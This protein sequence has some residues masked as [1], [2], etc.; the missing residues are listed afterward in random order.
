MTFE[1]EPDAA[2][3]LKCIRRDLN[4]EL[5]PDLQSA[6][7][8]GLAMMIDL[9]LRNVIAKEE[10]ASMLSPA[11]SDK[12]SV[13]AQAAF[14]RACDELEESQETLQATPEQAATL[15]VTPQRLTQYLRRRQPDFPAQRAVRVEPILGGFSKHTF[16]ADLQGGPLQSIVIRRD[17]KNG[18]IDSTASAEFA[19]VSTLYRSGIPVAEPL[20]VEQD[21][22]VFG[23]PF[24]VS[25]KV[26][27]SALSAALNIEVNERSQVACERLAEFLAQL[28]TLDLAKAQPPGWHPSLSTSMCIQQLIDEW[29]RIWLRK[30]WEESPI[31]ATAFAWLRDNI[32]ATSACPVL[33]HG[34][35]GLHNLMIEDGCTTAMLDW[36][37][38]HVGHGGED[39][40]YCRTWVEQA[41]PWEQFLK[42]YAA[43]GGPPYDE[44]GARFFKIF[45]DVRNCVCDVAGMYGFCKDEQPDIK[46]AYA[47][48]KYYRFYLRRLAEELQ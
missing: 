18:P 29:E 7:T 40:A 4:A 39:L 28:H 41:M 12:G 6:R 11:F 37:L 10:E 13:A 25:R 26:R 2:R 47:G 31:L 20:W 14:L 45:C 8:R 3:M 17:L 36:E 32:P 46:S 21:P 23:L 33:V 16:I 1:Y 43:H 5:L 48:I 15:A 35:A 19:M 22:A 24:Q 34:D 44:S 9:V 27:G 42:R 38:A 30:R